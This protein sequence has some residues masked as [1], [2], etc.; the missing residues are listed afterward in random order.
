MVLDVSSSTEQGPARSDFD[1]HN[2]LERVTTSR[3]DTLTFEA[4]GRNAY[5]LAC[6]AWGILQSEPGR[7]AFR[8]VRA[9]LVSLGAITDLSGLAG[10]Q[11]ERARFNLV[12]SVN[13]IIEVELLTMRRANIDVHYEHGTEH[14]RVEP[15]DDDAE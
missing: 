4:F 8:K 6:F 10:T 2:E 14:I 12:L 13:E 7:A 11:E 5:E 15:P 1:G 3:M 9:G